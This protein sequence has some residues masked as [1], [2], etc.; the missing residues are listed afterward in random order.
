MLNQSVDLERPGDLVKN[1][2]EKD[3]EQSVVS[4][5]HLVV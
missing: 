1:K 4:R 2:K 5:F 3:L